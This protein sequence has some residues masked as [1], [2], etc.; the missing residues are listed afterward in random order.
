MKIGIFSDLHVSSTGAMMKAGARLNYCK[1]FVDWFVE[2]MEDRG[3][4]GFIDIGDLTSSDTINAEEN[5]T[6]CYILGKLTSVPDTSILHVL[7]N[8]ERLDAGGEHHS[9]S[10]ANLVPGH[11]VYNSVEMLT[12]LSE[13]GDKILLVMIPYGCHDIASNL[14]TD[15][16]RSEYKKIYGF[17]HADLVPGGTGFIGLPHDIFARYDRVFNGHIHNPST[18]SNIVNVGSPLGS[19]LGDE[20]S[21]HKPGVIILDLDKNSF[22]FLE[23]PFA[24]LYYKVNTPEE[25]AKILTEVDDKSRLHLKFMYNESEKEGIE[26]VTSIEG[27]ASSKIDTSSIK[28]IDNG[29]VITM[30]KDFYQNDKE[31]VDEIDKILGG[32]Q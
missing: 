5:S 29:T 12:V 27:I 19:N 15:E 9:I 16:I 10:I 18:F 31:Y 6:L 25:Y 23:N 7:G 32:A 2:T 26:S 17:S 14:I 28:S 3:V 21:Y 20:Y 24:P 22:V 8:H 11:T 4:V 30:L 13:Q 1:K